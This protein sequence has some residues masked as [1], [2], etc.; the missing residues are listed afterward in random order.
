[1]NGLVAVSGLSGCGCT[2]PRAAG[3]TAEASTTTYPLATYVAGGILLFALGFVMW[4]DKK[5]A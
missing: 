1:M 5:L 3:E 4:G 2:R